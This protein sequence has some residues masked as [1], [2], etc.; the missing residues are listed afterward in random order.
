VVSRKL[1]ERTSLPKGTRGYP[2]KDGTT[3]T[4]AGE[5]SPNIQLTLAGY[6]GILPTLIA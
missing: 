2:P 1:L 6:L 3:V 4:I 5:N